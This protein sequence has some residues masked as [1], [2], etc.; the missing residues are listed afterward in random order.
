MSA[1]DGTSAAAA[2]DPVAQADA[3]RTQAAALRR[4]ADQLDAQAAALQPALPS[5]GG[6]ALADAAA[7]VMGDLG[8]APIHYKDLLPLVEAHTGLA[9]RGADPAATL[10][11]ALHR[12]PRIY[13]SGDRS[14]RYRLAQLSLAA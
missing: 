10:L 12:D 2:A 5:I 7:A 4:I 1:P 11:A 9:V 6:T 13:P 8:G 14:G 3:L